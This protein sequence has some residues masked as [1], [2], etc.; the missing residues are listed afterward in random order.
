MCNK[1]EHFNLRN[2]I[3]TVVTL[4]QLPPCNKKGAVHDTILINCMFIFY[5]LLLLKLY[6]KPIIYPDHTI[7]LS[8]LVCFFAWW[9]LTPLLAIFQLYRGDQFFLVEETGR[10]GENH[11]SVACKW[12]TLSH[13]VVRLAPWS[14]FEHQWW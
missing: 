8:W 9:C 14:R 3:L 4:V 13:N 10:P 7:V 6:I 11:W 2:I 1:S 5:W 12:R